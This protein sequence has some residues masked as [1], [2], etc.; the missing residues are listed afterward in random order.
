[1]QDDH[2]NDFETATIINEIP[3]EGIIESSGDVDFFSFFALKS[4]SY[5]IETSTFMD[6]VY[7]VYDSYGNEIFK[8]L[9]TCYL[10][11]LVQVNILIPVTCEI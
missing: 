4:G 6:I 10:A 5:T 3:I 7:C 9:N 11:P 1:M 8:D 2:G